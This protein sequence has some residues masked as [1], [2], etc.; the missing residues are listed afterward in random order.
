MRDKYMYTDRLAVGYG[1]KILIDDIDINVEK[2]HIIALIGPN[3]AG[4]STILKT[5]I[6]QLD[7]KGG[8]VYL[9][10]KKMSEMSGHEVSVKMSVMMTDRLKT[11]LMTCRDVVNTGRY[12][13]T[14]RLGILSA[15][16]HE[17]VDEA[18]ELV[19][20]E[21]IADRD[22]MEISDGQRQRIMLAKAICQEPEIIVLD[23]PTSFL[24]IRHKLELISILKKMVKERNIAVI[25]SLHEI[26]LAQKVA[27][28]IVCVKGDRIDRSGEPDEIFTSDY[29]GKL[30]DIRKGSYNELFGGIELERSGGMAEVFVISGNGTGIP[31]YRK[32][33]REG[34]PF[35]TG[36]IHE[37]D[38]DCQVAEALAVEVIKEKA[39]NHITDETFERAVEIMNKCKS[40]KCTLDVFGDI[41]VENKK[42]YEIAK[43]TGKKIL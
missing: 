29:I 22:F 17:K 5:I 1:N 9:A 19:G 34:I 18:I 38:V 3:G 40:V 8:T 6:G 4:K 37:N 35:A 13:Y 7:S 43:S 23:E 15:A 27:D 31:Y 39:F 33:Q 14:G 20:G 16:D 10:G 41:N 36:I 12:P 21:D 28:K 42:L 24:D 32:C 2:G 26:D 25:M 11:E 30:Y